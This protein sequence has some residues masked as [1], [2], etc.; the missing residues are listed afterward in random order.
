MMAE[1][2]W[3]N[4]CQANDLKDGS[5]IEFTLDGTACFAF[6]LNV[7]VA[8]Y[9]NRCP[10]LGIELNW[11]PQRFFDIERTFI[12]CSTHGALFTPDRGTCIA[13]PCQGDS[14]SPLECVV[15]DGAVMVRMP[16]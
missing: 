8:A 13:G 2:R 16:E 10:H 15:R 1:H 7:L 3:Q 11:M 6:K 9:V 12:Q 14:L 5:A 4:V